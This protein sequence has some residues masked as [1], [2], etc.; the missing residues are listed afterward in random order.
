LQAPQAQ[1]GLAQNLFFKVGG[2]YHR[3]YARTADV[4]N[5][6]RY[7]GLELPTM[8][9]SITTKGKASCLPPAEPLDR[10]SNPG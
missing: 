8:R 9:N 2:F 1:G 4:H 10:R 7:A 3:S 5:M 6:L